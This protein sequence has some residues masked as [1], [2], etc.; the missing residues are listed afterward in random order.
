MLLLDPLP[1]IQDEMTGA[2]RA[3]RKLGLDSTE[4][5]VKHEAVS[6][7]P[8]EGSEVLE[9]VADPESGEIGEERPQTIRGTSRSRARGAVPNYFGRL[10]RR[11]KKNTKRPNRDEEVKTLR[12]ITRYMFEGMYPRGPAVDY[13]FLMDKKNIAYLAEYLDRTKSTAA[14]LA[15]WLTVYHH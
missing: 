2:A 4:P 14:S 6:P 5:A 8:N 7:S 10:F 15:E 11:S 1:A 3:L 12:R 9:R 13:D